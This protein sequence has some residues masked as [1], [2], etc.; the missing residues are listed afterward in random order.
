MYPNPLIYCT[1]WD[2]WNLEPRKLIKT[3][4]PPKKTS[5][6]KPKPTL[7]PPASK[8]Q[9]Y[10]QP[11]TKPVV[12]PKV[13]THLRKQEESNNLPSEVINV[14]PGYRLFRN[15]EQISVTLGDEMFDRKK[16][17]K[18]EIMDKIR[19]R[20]TDIIT[21]LEEQISELTTIIEQM[22]TDHQSAK[23]TLSN[24]ME[25]RC[26]EMKQDFENKSRELKEAHAAELS[27]MENNYKAALK[28]EKLASQEKLE[29]MGKEYK[30]L[31]NMFFMYQDSLY[32]EMED[33]LSKKK[34]EWEKDE[35][36]ER[37]K[38]L[39]QQ[40]NTM[41]KKF[42]LESEEEKKKLSESYS[43]LF[44]N[45]TQ[46]KEELLKQ[47]E[48][49]TLQLKELKKTN[50][51]IEEE[52]HAQAII[53]ESLNTTLYQTQMELQK[54][55]AAVANLEKTLQT[56]LA[57]TEE[58]FKFTIQLLREE[59]I[60]LRQ[61]INTKNGGIYEERSGRSTCITIYEDDTETLE[62]GSNKRQEL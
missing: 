2:P 27:E 55:K 4:Q 43:T 42:E 47:H 36:S 44:E 14:C 46:E 53:L 24:E 60:H 3:P 15:R 5:T 49:D 25:I 62:E 23:T 20:R 30:Y 35:K 61:K 18:S 33:K 32:D 29:E 7:L 12:S 9:N 28:E 6:G 50:E 1:C 58:K 41:T 38:I 10:V 34:A 11:P 40:K 19:I 26:A 22:N 48:K 17:L 52:L 51:I 59:N 54:E 56:K 8:K 37:E 39:L 31:K 57:E 13:K 16:R 45:V 21:D